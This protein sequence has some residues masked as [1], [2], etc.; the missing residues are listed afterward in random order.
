MAA[1][2]NWRARALA[3]TGVYNL[4]LWTKQMKHHGNFSPVLTGIA[5]N[6]LWM[7]TQLISP[8]IKKPK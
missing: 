4:Q 7:R 6:S 1:P 5:I 3:L 8:Q 2:K